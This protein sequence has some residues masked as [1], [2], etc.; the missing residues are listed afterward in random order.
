MYKRFLRWSTDRIGASGIVV[1][2]SNNSFLDAKSDDGFRQVVAKEFDYIYTVNLKG[3]A[4]LAG[5]A[6]KREGGK[7][8]GSGARV[9]ITIT[10]FLKTGEGKS[11]I[12][13]A[14]IDD[15][16]NRE[17]KFKWLADN[18]I[19]TLPLRQIVPDE[20]AIWLNQ[21]NN[22]FDELVP[23]ANEEYSV[24]KSLSMGITTA[25]NEWVYDFDK[26]SL[27]NKI[28]YFINTYNKI[29]GDSIEENIKI[30]LKN[31]KIELKSLKDNYDLDVYYKI[32]LG[33]DLL[34]KI[35][36]CK[37]LKY[38][39]KNTNFT[40]YR[41]F[42]KKHLYF[43]NIIIDYTRKFPTIFKNSKS[44][45]LI[46][47]SNPKTNVLFQTLA[48]NKIID[49]D[50][51]INTQCIPLYM[52]NDD[53]K[54]FSNITKFGLDL[55][56]KHY[57]NKKI[58]D[59]D[60][61]YYTY[62]IFNDPKY[63]K[64]YEFNLQ[65]KFP[66]IPLAENFEAWAKIGKEL[67]DIHV[68][69]E[70]AVPYP[71]KRIDKNTNKNKTKLQLKKSKDS[72][73]DIKIIIDDQTAL[74]GIPVDVLEYRFSSKCAL[75]WILEFYKES[76]NIISEK[77]CDDPKI[78]ERFNTYRFSDHK[79]YVIDSLQKVTT[80]SVETMKLRAELKNMPYGKQ[81]KRNPRESKKQAT[82]KKPKKMRSKKTKSK[83]SK[84]K[85][86]RLQNTLDEKD[87]HTL[88]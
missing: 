85:A 30:E 34:K 46:S 8:F 82:S 70:N 74:E 59:E 53:G 7:I 71:L 12:H 29:L 65:R 20:D 18:S 42:V 79:E 6:W 64:K 80:V 38:S 68:G 66:R 72:D 11:E 48:T 1:F 13:Y 47:F 49:Y 16:T 25:R 60:I 40:L 14:E 22:D 32:K 28:E 78:R 75:E 58:T 21:T 88:S 9:G 56:Q 37:Q 39:K 19:S 15:Y 73:D 62:A 55:F 23:I 77:S 36:S 63:Q 44:N 50:C 3:N 54:P 5:D 33:R 4:R 51:V 87:Q 52:Y 83:R 41:P 24:F 43:D 31:G 61:F 76:K 84:K 69:F 67:Y 27:D 45:K 81:P 57:K 17:D 26:N 10:F 86:D 35:K 2:I